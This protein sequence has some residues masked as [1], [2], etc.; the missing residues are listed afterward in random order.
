VRYVSNVQLDDAIVHIINSE[1]SNTCILSE[2]PIPLAASSQLVDYFATHIVNALRDPTARA[3]RFRALA[4]DNVAGIC[5]CLVSG[6]IDLVTGSRHLAERLHEIV[7]NDA[8][9]KPGSLA[10]IAYRANRGTTTERYLALMKIDPTSALR[11]KTECDNQGRLY[12][13]FEVASD[14]MPTTREKLQKCAFVQSLAPRLDY[15][16]MLLDRQVNSQDSQP[17]AKFFSDT[18]LGATM[19]LDSQQRTHRF[20]RAA[21][22]AQNQLRAQLAPQESDSL[23]QAIDTA[24]TSEWLNL[25]SWLAALPL[26]EP[27]KERVSEVIAQQLPDREFEIDRS[28]ANK[29]LVKRKFAGDYDLRV[30]VSADN[31]ESVI[32][33]TERVEEPGEPPRW[34]IVI[35]TERWDEVLR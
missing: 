11:P 33:S 2:R 19:A 23:R 16:M 15:D 17:V 27:Q 22:S 21:V 28:Y 9:I 12:I 13:S 30:E 32:R 29:L 6:G 10:V 18:F 26:A 20:Y 3:A 4:S 8:R 14:I 35:E 24:I 1:H 5:G 7:A 34:R 31:L 25:D